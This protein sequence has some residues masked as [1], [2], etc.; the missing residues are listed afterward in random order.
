MRRGLRIAAAGLAALA[1][2]ALLLELSVAALVRA[3]WLE[4]PPPAGPRSRFWDGEHP[5]FGVWHRPGAAILHESACF[6]VRYRTNALGARD[7][8]RSAVADAPRVLALGD[9]FVEGW[10]VPRAKRLTDRLEAATGLEHVNLAMA[11]FGPYQSLLVYRELGA[12]L[13][14]QLVLIG[15]VPH[16]DFTDLDYTRASGALAYRYRFRPY[17][18]GHY[19][20]YRHVD[21]REASWARVLRRHSYAWNALDH[22]RTL[23]LGSDDPY[24]PRD[25]RSAAGVVRS[26]YYDYGEDQL[27]LLRFVLER[28]AAEAAPRPVVAFLI[29]TLADLERRA[30]AG[31]APLGPALAAAVRGAGVRVIDLLPALREREPHPKRLFFACDYH[32]NARGNALAAEILRA[33]LAGEYAVLAAARAAR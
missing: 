9:S 1:A 22:A 7:R 8:E 17:L 3:G 29:P 25:L 28:L 27:D 12:A 5:R 21:H 23:L 6:S 16:N 11:H 15:V 13:E 32:W 10:G 24:G 18:V 30:Q 20:S 2:T 19:P 14:H 4:T 31:P 26:E 33:E